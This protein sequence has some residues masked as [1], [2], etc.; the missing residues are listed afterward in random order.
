MYRKQTRGLQRSQGVP[1]ARS[2]QMLRGIPLF[3]ASI[4]I[5]I[6]GQQMPRFTRMARCRRSTPLWLEKLVLESCKSTRV[7]FNLM[8]VLKVS[9]GHLMTETEFNY[10]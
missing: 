8:P 9:L 7:R 6:M 3:V 10:L 5:C 4:A 2:R 1:V